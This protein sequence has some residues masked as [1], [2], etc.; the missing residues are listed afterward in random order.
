M[1]HFRVILYQF[2]VFV[3]FKKRSFRKAQ[4]LQINFDHFTY[5][6]LSL[7]SFRSIYSFCFQFEIFRLVSNF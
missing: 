1:F 4:L 5:F 7:K 6:A 2:K 3:I